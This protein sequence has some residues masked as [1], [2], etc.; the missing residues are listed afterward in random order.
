V[1]VWDREAPPQF[2]TTSGFLILEISDS[3]FKP[4]AR[5]VCPEGTLPE[6]LGQAA[7]GRSTVL[8]RG[9]ESLVHVGTMLESGSFDWRWKQRLEPG[10]GAKR[11]SR[12]PFF[13][14]LGERLAIVFS[15]TG[16]EGAPA[17][18][19]TLQ[20]GPEATSP[21]PLCEPNEDCPLVAMVVAQGILHV[22]S[23]NKVVMVSSTGQ[24]AVADPLASAKLRPGELPE[25]CVSQGRDG[26]VTIQLPVVGMTGAGTAESPTRRETSIATLDYEHAWLPHGPDVFPTELASCGPRGFQDAEGARE[27]P[28]SLRENARATF[29]QRWLI[30]Y[31]LPEVRPA[32]ALQHAFRDAQ[33]RRTAFPGSVRVLRGADVLRPAP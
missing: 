6:S 12:V 28:I 15:A 11:L 1:L 24:V 21:I 26:K 32:S 2:A 25:P 13:A 19:W 18:P 17:P 31:G 7:S 4:V 20:L 3:G 22:V 27:V 33:G 8:C 5:G 23:R 10:G 30:V 16:A 9:S 29:D 14:D